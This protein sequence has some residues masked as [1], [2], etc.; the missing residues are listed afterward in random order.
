MVSCKL[1]IS[2]I[3][4]K[5]V[6]E[7]RGRS[8]SC[9]LLPSQTR[10]RQSQPAGWQREATALHC[11]CC[12]G[13]HSTGSSAGKKGLLE[14]WGLKGNTSFFFFFFSPHLAGMRGDQWTQLKLFDTI[15]HSLGFWASCSLLTLSHTFTNTSGGCGAQETWGT[16]NSTLISTSLPAKHFWVMLWEAIPKLANAPG[17]NNAKLFSTQTTTK[18]GFTI[19][20]WWLSCYLGSVYRQL[21]DFSVTKWIDNTSNRCS[22]SASE[23]LFTFLRNSILTHMHSWFADIRLRITIFEEWNIR[24]FTTCLASTV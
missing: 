10:S 9:G 7:K 6:P 19:T 4:K 11:Q 18:K 5:P 8:K 23:K 24:N 15:F 21:L 14:V 1:A 13:R 22:I 17:I 3:S 20:S 2:F 16:G 12:P